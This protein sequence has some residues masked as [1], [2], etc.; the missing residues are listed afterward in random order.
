MFSVKAIIALRGYHVYKESSWSNAKLND[1]VKVELQMDAKS[2]STDLYVCAIK[3]RHSYFVGWKTVR[4]I[5]REISRYVYFFIKKENGKGF[6][7]LKSL[8]YKVS[9]IPSGILE[10]PLSLTFLCKE[11]WV[12]DSME[13]FIQNVYIFEYSRNQSVDTSDSKDEEDDYQTI[14]LEPENEVDEEREKSQSDKI[15]LEIDKDIPV[16]VVID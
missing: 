14:V 15:D 3:S 10:V 12:V 8:K 2:L 1:E 5:P 11:K 13:K 9:P 7:T 4:H 6:G 16:P